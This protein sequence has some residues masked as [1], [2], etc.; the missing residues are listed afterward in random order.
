M[1]IKFN[2]DETTFVTLSSASF[3]IVAGINW[4]RIICLTPLYKSN[5]YNTAACF[6]NKKRL[7][8]NLETVGGVF[9]RSIKRP[10]GPTS[11]LT[12]ISFSFRALAKIFFV[13][14]MIAI[15]ISSSH[16]F[17]RRISSFLAISSRLSATSFCNFSLTARVYK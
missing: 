15:V 12:S 9:I 14:A 16:S 7:A 13:S 1:S 5:S 11:T 8:Y 10:R 2:F 4:K 6:I 17:T 3:L